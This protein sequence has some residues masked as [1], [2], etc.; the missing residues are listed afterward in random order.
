[1]ASSTRSTR[2]AAAV[3]L[4]WKNAVGDTRNVGPSAPLA[5]VR[6]PVEAHRLAADHVRR[7][8][9]VDVQE[10][11]VGAIGATPAA[12]A[13]AVRSAGSLRVTTSSATAS[14]SSALVRTITCRSTPSSRG[15]AGGDPRLDQFVAQAEGDAVGAGAVHRALVAPA[16]SSRP[17]AAKWPIDEP[18][19]GAAAEDER[20]LVAEVP[21]ACRRRRPASARPAP[22]AA[23]G[24]HGARAAGASSARACARAASG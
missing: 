21:R 20:R 17:P 6:V 18:A 22:P 14:R 15:P 13:P 3:G 4:V 19:C 11:A 10:E 8:L 1:M 23:A 24:G 16:R 7:R 2:A 12:R 9:I 5:H